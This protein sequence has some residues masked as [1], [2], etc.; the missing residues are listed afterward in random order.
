M[1][2]LQL[3]LRNIQIESNEGSQSPSSGDSDSGP[4][5]SVNGGL[6]L[7]PTLP[8]SFL[9]LIP[10]NSNCSI[11]ACQREK[12]VYRSGFLSVS[13]RG[14]DGIVEEPSVA[15]S[16]KNGDKSSG[17]KERT[18][19][20]STERKR[21]K[22]MVRG[23]GRGAVNTTK[24]L[25]AGAIAAMVSRSVISFRTLVNYIFSSLVRGVPLW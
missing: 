6:F 18:S 11:M 8:P 10:L 24:H 14:G 1:P 4:V 2:S 17:S 21:R 9:H 25:W 23:R 3:F 5:V 12:G 16:Q 20:V 7:D 13:L 19:V 15:L 22:V